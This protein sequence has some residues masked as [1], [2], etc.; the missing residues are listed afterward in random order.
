MPKRLTDS[1]KW[2]DPWFRNL[3][4]PY[5]EFWIYICDTCD[6]AGLWK[7]DFELASFC[8]REEINESEAIKHF[9]GR[10]VNLSEKWFI[11][12]FLKFQ[13]EI[14]NLKRPV[15]FSVVKI[16]KRELEP[17]LFLRYVKPLLLKEE[18]KSLHDHSEMIKSKSKSKSKRKDKEVILLTEH[19]INGHKEFTE[20]WCNE[21]FRR[22]ASKYVFQAAK[23]GSIVKRLLQTHSLEDLKLLAEAF[24]EDKDEFVEKAGR[25]LSIFSTQI[26]RIAQNMSIIKFRKAVKDG[27]PKS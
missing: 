3:A 6:H 16:L 13:Y 12:K 20:Y 21:F 5:R 14:L 8:L 4:K 26:N 15:C 2:A 19:H 11:P 9:D 18:C 24:F 25:T 22:F 17:N 27:S 1:Q 7:K 10:I 23:D